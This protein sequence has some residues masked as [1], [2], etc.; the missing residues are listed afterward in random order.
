MTYMKVL[1]EAYSIHD[2]LFPSRHTAEQYEDGKDTVKKVYVG[3]DKGSSISR[4]GV[5]SCNYNG[6]IFHS[7]TEALIEINHYN[8]S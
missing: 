7:K 5:S 6:W 1:Q 4:R 3:V 2:T 8:E